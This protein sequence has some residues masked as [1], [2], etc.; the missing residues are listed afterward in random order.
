MIGRAMH[1]LANE[2][3]IDDMT[4]MNGWVIMYLCHHRNNDV[5]QKDIE[6]EMK[7][8]KSSVTGIV[9]MMEQKGYITR[10]AVAGDARLK[11]IV[12]T[13]EGEK[14]KTLMETSF[15][16]AERKLDKCLSTDEQNQLLGLIGKL[17]DG[18]TEDYTI[19]RAE[20]RS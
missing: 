8:T 7:I 11:K 6:R 10:T 14:M 12:I 18:L 5:F 2:K 4:M 16:E 9:Q 15:D 19:Y 1:M 17:D 20:H 3:G 13:K